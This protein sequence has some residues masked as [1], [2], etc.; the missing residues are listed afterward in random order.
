LQ[1]YLDGSLQRFSLPL[2]WSRT[3]GFQR[4]VLQVVAGI[5]FGEL[6]SYG[7]I[8]KLVGKPGASRAVGAA[9]GSNPWLIVVPCHRVIGSDRKLHG[10][11]APGGLETKTWL[12]RHEG[13]EIIRGTLSLKG[14]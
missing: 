11:S 5:P 10:F 2:A 3:E 9:V 1:A 12:L 7:E 13:H 8:A 4:E 14:S 6:M